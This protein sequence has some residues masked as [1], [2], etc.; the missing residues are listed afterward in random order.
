MYLYYFILILILSGIG[1]LRKDSRQLY[2]IGI[3][4]ILFVFSSLRGYICGGDLANYLPHFKLINYKSIGSI[5]KDYDKYG[6]IFNLINKLIGFVSKD[7]TVY[8]TI[9][10]FLNLIVPVLFIKKL[11]ITP[12][13]SFF[14]Y[15]AMGF[16]TNTFNS[17]RSSLAISVS[18]LGVLFLFQ[19]K[20]LAALIMFLVGVEIHKTLL[21]I[22]LIFFVFDRKPNLKKYLIVVVSCS[23]FASVLGSSWIG[24]LIQAYAQF[25]NY[26]ENIA[27][28]SGGGYS[29]L[30]LDTMILCGSVYLYQRGKNRRSY[31]LNRL[32]VILINLF[33]IGTCIQAFA[34]LYSLLT[35][36]SYFFII[37]E[38]I[39]IPNVLYKSMIESTKRIV[40][41]GIVLM[42]SLYFNHFI[43]TPSETHMKSNSQ[44]TLPYY[45]YWEK[46]PR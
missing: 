1:V 29:L 16:Y 41:T 8:I 28:M 46:A 15:I 3:F 33:F 27:D 42:S 32:L 36:I 9:F 2:C 25:N 37:Y 23:V 4:I 14:L 7:Y 24:G 26:G 21:P 20:K 40:I 38:I 31:E 30:L 18:M 19:N 34:P 12:W 6:I 13:L 11:S 44:G 22:L 5:L 35:R 45:F 39:L 10:S 17:V 43:M